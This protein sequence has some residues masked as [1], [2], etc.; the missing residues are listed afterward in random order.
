MPRFRGPGHLEAHTATARRSLYLAA[1]RVWCCHAATPHPAPSPAPPSLFISKHLSAFFSFPP[2][3]QPP[4]GGLLMSLDDMAAGFWSSEKGA[5]LKKAVE[6]A[7]AM[8]Y[9]GPKVSG[10]GVS[11]GGREGGL[12]RREEGYVGGREAA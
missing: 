12:R 4:G 1:A 7:E 11:G 10:G 5:E 8:Q 3:L 2:P 6:E 9:G